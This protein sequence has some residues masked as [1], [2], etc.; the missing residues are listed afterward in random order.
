MFDEN[1]LCLHEEGLRDY[2]KNQDE[3]FKNKSELSK[4]FDE[5]NAIIEWALQNCIKV[6]NINDTTELSIGDNKISVGYLVTDEMFGPAIDDLPA[7]ERLRGINNQISKLFAN[8]INNT[9]AIKAKKMLYMLGGFDFETNQMDDRFRIISNTKSGYDDFAGTLESHIRASH[10]SS[11]FSDNTYFFE[12]MRFI[13]FCQGDKL[14]DNLLHEHKIALRYPNVPKDH[15]SEEANRQKEILKFRFPLKFFWMWANKNTVIHPFSLMAFRNFLK[16]EFA[17]NILE[18]AKK[19]TV[20]ASTNKDDLPHKVTNCAFDDFVV[21]WK[22]FSQ[23]IIR[24]V[25]E[26]NGGHPNDDLNESEIKNIANQFS[27]LISIIMVADTDIK[28]IEELLKVTKQ[29][30]LYG[31]PGTGKTYNA[32]K[33]AKQ[34]IDSTDGLSESDFEKKHRF[35]KYRRNETAEITGFYE[36]IQFHP[37]YSYQDFI[38]G[39]FPS[40]AGNSLSYE[41]KEGIFKRFCDCASANPDKFFVFIIDEINRANLSEV[42]GELLYAL[43]YRDKAISLPYFGEF[44]IPSNVFIIGT[45]NNVD[46]SLVTFDLALR[47]RFG[48]YKLNADMSVLMH[49]LSDYSNIQLYV[50]KCAWLNRIIINKLKDDEKTEYKHKT[51]DLSENYQIGHAYY[52]KVKEYIEKDAKII[53]SNHLQKLWEYHIEPLLEEYLGMSLESEEIKRKLSEIKKD[54]IKLQP[55]HT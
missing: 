20:F 9:I 1:E 28:N 44:V 4:R 54:F 50:E 49:K 33:V 35:I 31:P 23:T 13:Y 17:K 12:I 48:F 11:H 16:T 39:I 34:L 19:A 32:M 47:R 40:I 14:P 29:I 27:K 6:Q 51:L 30:I 8:N 38:G 42:F 45:M 53:Q 7:D 21:I 22:S 41:L 25:H 15:Y 24:K 18:N 46:K 2:W 26:F 36:I 5:I 37:N 3:I 52:L 43:E 55:K 10:T